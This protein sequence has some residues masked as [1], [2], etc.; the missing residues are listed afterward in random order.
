MDPDNPFDYVHNV[1]LG[2][3]DDETAYHVRAW[4]EDREGM[5]Y[6]SEILRFE[7][8]PATSLETNV[9]A[10]AVGASISG[11][12]SN[13]GNGSDDSTWGALN[14]IDGSF[15]TEWSSNGDGDDAYLE[16]DFGQ[17]R[18]IAEVR[19]QSR[20]MTDGTSIIQRLSLFGDGAEAYGSFGTPSPDVVYT[21]VLDPPLSTRV[22]RMEVEQS[23][24]GNTGAK[25]LQAFETP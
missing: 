7:T 6:L 19:F 13:F 12:S 22:L 15:A 4:A 17:V 25:E 5:V 11:V 3:L 14:A 9:A 21:L 16:V 10:A 8:E 23:T 2:G 24:G 20:Q 18:T 1:P